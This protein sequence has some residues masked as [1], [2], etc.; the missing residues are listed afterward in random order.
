VTL[1]GIGDTTYNIVLILHLASVFVA[2]APAVAHPTGQLRARRRGPEAEQAT[3]ADTAAVTRFLYLP[4]LVVSGLLGLALL[5]LSGGVWGF[6]QIWVSL[7]FLGWIA[8][9]GVVFGLVLPSERR[10]AAG[11]ATARRT[12]DRGWLLVNLG[13]LGMLY[14]MVFK[15]DT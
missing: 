8:L 12:L 13:L 10:V 7:S 14:L 11:D 9:A 15:P 5:G 4:A 1:A 6:H 2:F 3:V